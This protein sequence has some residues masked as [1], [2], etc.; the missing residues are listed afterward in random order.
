MLANIFRKFN[1]EAITP[2]N[3]LKIVPDVI[4]R[5]EDGVKVKI[6]AR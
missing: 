6:K 2:A 4:L 5:T 3:G 1:V